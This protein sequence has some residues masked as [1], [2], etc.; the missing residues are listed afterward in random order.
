MRLAEK[1]SLKV[2]KRE[3]KGKNMSRR[4]RSPRPP[5]TCSPT[6]R[7]DLSDGLMPRSLW[8]GS[9]SFGL[10]NVPITLFSGVDTDLHFRQ[11][12]AKDEHADR[13]PPLLR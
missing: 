5:T 9:L 4:T 6:A 7:A 1:E 8:S 3:A 10:V 11:L 12:H 2:V 13:G